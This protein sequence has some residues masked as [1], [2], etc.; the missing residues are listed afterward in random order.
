MSGILLKRI[1]ACYKFLEDTLIPLYN[2]MHISLYTQNIPEKLFF[3]NNLKSNNI[4]NGLKEI[5]IK[6]IFLVYISFVEYR[7]LLKVN[8]YL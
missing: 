8:D 2:Q 7:I 6:N 5:Y 1:K 4:L 3:L